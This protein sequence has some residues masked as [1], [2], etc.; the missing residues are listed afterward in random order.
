MQQELWR[1]QN[2]G[3]WYRIVLVDDHLEWHFSRNASL[4][5]EHET[6]TFSHILDDN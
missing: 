4:G 1:G 6:W 5:E 2:R 3:V